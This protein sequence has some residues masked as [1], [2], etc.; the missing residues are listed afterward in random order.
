MNWAE[1]GQPVMYALGSWNLKGRIVDLF[2]CLLLPKD[3]QFGEYEII[4]PL[5]FLLG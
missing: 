1:E 4:F 2:I 3:I 5:I